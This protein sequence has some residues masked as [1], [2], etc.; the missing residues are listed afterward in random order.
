VLAETQ[1][2]SPQV[3]SYI[4]DNGASNGKKKSSGRQSSRSNDIESLT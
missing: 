2:V 4:A 1:R 3:D